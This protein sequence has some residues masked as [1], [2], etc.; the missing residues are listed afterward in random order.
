MTELNQKTIDKIFEKAK[1][2]SDYTLG[3]YLAVIP[4]FYDL[5]VIEGWPEVSR[6]TN[7]YISDKAIEF[8]KIHHPHV[9]AGGLWM[10][11]GFSSIHGHDKNWTVYF[12]HC[13]FVYDE[14]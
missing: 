9:V 4:D 14:H 6:D 11:K 13:K 1:E 7:L 5:K 3:L 8:D 10:N 2:Q 12:N